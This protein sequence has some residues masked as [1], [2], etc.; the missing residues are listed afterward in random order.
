V[1]AYNDEP[2]PGGPGIGISYSTDGGA[3]WGN[4]HLPVP[5]SS[6]S[7]VKLMDAF[8]PSITID[9]NGNL[10]AA[11]IAT[12]ANWWT[13]PV[14]GLFVSKSTDG[15][16]TWP[17]LSPVDE[18]PAPNGGTDSAY[19]L[20]DRDQII[21]DRYP[22]SPYYN[23]IY[24]AWI[25]DRGW[26]MPVPSGDIYFSYSTDGGVTFSPAHRINS[27]ANNLGNM[28]TL[29][30]GKDGSI[31]VA[32]MDYNVQT[33]GQGVI[34]L[35]KS[36]DGGASWGPDI[37]VDTID[38]PPLH[39]NM[40]TGVRAKGAPVIRV[41]PSDPNYLCIVFAEDPDGTGPDEGDIFMRT[42]TDGGNTWPK[43]NKVR[44]NDDATT[45]GQI[46]PWVVIKNND[47]I[48]IAWY[49]KRND[50][51]DAI[52][53][54]Y[55]TYSTDKGMSF[56]PNVR[57]NQ[58]SFYPPFVPKTGDNWF[59]EYLG[60]AADYNDAY[61]VYSSAY[62]DQLGDVIFAPVP[63]AQPYK[64]YGDAPDP[65][66]PILSINS[67]ASHIYVSGVFLGSLIDV[68]PDG[69][70]NAGATGD[71]DS[72]LKDEDGVT[73]PSP[74]LI[75]QLDT[76]TIIASTAAYLNAWIDYNGNGTWSDPGEQ[77]FTDQMLNSGT[78]KLP[79]IVPGGTSELSTYARFRLS[80]MAGI[81][82]T[83][84]APDGEVEDYLVVL[85]DQTGINSWK[86]PGKGIN[87]FPNPATDKIHISCEMANSGNR[88]ISISDLMG[89]I[90]CEVQFNEKDEMI[91]NVSGLPDGLYIVKVQSGEN[92]IYG[93][94]L[95]VH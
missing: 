20:N 90:I 53:D 52:F 47:I 32:W 24:I 70:P 75:G 41:L 55:Y 82:Y 93:K 44:V 86:D 29:D 71:D 65:S 28:P 21:C 12:D 38:L 6:I 62:Y 88:T 13:G 80:T 69:L 58:F 56:A 51:N 50:V 10:Y 81:S 8:D 3:T 18:Q 14:T 36:P 63:N 7:G 37:P 17:L 66:F 61:I 78:N 27:W 31:Y 84:E 1:A 4:T 73:I 33:G 26:N 59:G 85:D 39:L 91:H 64:D 43:A 19:R 79:I 72:N 94:L 15:G 57:V 11:Q 30:V 74:L 87:I 23:N 67:G 42:S 22:S 46:L 2:F 40:N 35:D 49:D 77:I 76:I 48:D 16:M 89:N 5:V 60:L 9:G 83:G 25:Q 92:V 34:F 54:V 45:N 68:E 95:V